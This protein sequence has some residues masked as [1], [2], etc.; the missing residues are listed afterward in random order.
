MAEAKDY[1]FKVASNCTKCSACS[2]VCPS[3]IIVMAADGPTLPSARTCI[4]CGHCVAVCPVEAL[5]YSFAPLANQL[6]INPSLAI[7]TDQAEQFLRTRRSIRSY[8]KVEV[9]TE[10]LEKLVNIAHYAPTGGNSQNISYVVIK[11]EETIKKLSDLT[12]DWIEQMSKVSVSF[13][14]YAN[15]VKVGRST[16]ADIIFRG[17]SAVIVAVGI[18]KMPMT[19][20]NGHFSLAYAELL[21]PTL[22]LGTCWA[23][24][25]EMSLVEYQKEAYQILGLSE[26]QMVVGALMVGYPKYHYKRLVDRNPLNV[27][28]I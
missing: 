15:L 21:A 9:A 27:T 23:G 22:G 19:R 17:A 26:E 18:R 8:R 11:N 2:H 24:F 14:Q 4:R 13:R 7:T 10:K 5:D 6:K 25:F 20:D 1:S 3:G 12:L 28:L 16:G